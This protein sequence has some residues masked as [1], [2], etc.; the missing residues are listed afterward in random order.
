M[1]AVEQRFEPG[2]LVRAAE[3]EDQ[4]PDRP[5]L[6]GDVE[7]VGMTA[8]GIV[9]RAAERRIE[10]LALGVREG[11]AAREE[12]HAAVVDRAGRARVL[13][14]LLVFGRVGEREGGRRIA[15]EIEV[16]FGIAAADEHLEAVG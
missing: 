13:P 12:Q 4:R 1:P 6:A 10:Q 2:P 15:V 16:A 5:P 11:P 3:C 7:P 8:G 14:G 9:R